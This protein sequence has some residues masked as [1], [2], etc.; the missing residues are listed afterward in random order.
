MYEP[1][2]ATTEEDVGEHNGVSVDGNGEEAETVKHAADPG[3]PTMKQVEEHRETHTPFSSWCKWCVLGRGRGIQHRK[4][5]AST[6]SLVG[7]DYFFLTKG[8]VHTRK[9][10]EFPLTPEGESELE[11]ARS[12]GELVKY[13]LVRCFQQKAVFAHLV[14]RKALMRRTSLATWF[15]RTSN[16]LATRASS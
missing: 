14:P 6:V 7:V 12:R 1:L 15:S 3:A 2:I 13:F 10:L 11:A 5:G 4:A 9:E 16:G 8:G